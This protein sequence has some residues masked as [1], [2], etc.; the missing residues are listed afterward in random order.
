MGALPNDANDFERGG[1]AF[2]TVGSRQLASLAVGEGDRTT[3]I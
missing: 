2:Q 1:L 3:I